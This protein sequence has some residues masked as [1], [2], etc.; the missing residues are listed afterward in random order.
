MKKILLSL[1]L[2]LIVGLASQ[3]QDTD[4]EYQAAMVKMLEVSKSMD[5]ME[6]LA[7]QIIAMIKQQAPEAPQAF[8]DDLEKTMMTMYDQ[9]IKEMIPVYHKFLTLQDIKGIIQFYE[10]PVGQKLAESNTKIAMET[11]PIAQKIA[12]ET[13]QKMMTTAKEKGYIK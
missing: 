12:M 2:C 11:M 4:K 6:Q 5:A 10:T 8:W 1:M 3:A 13:M 7:P 9:I